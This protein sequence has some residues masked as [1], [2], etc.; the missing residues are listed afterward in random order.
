MEAEEELMPQVNFGHFIDKFPVVD[1]PIILSE[2]SIHDFSNENDPL[3]LLMIQQYLSMPDDDEYTEYI[4]CF[5]FPNP[6]GIQ[7]I[8]YWKAGLLDYQ[9][10][11]ATFTTKGVPVDLKILSG[12]TVVDNKIIQSVASID[13]DWIITVAAGQMDDKESVYDATTSRMTSMELM[14][15]GMIVMNS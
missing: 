11:L 7:A 12:L 6:T 2:E 1:L 9:Y 3:P 8:V 15:N 4:P 5:R 10:I 13:E 14:A